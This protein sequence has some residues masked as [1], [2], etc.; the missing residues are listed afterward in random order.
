MAG[1]GGAWDNAKKPLKMAF[2]A[3]KDL[4]LIMLP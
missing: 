3:E 1:A 2:M 4:K